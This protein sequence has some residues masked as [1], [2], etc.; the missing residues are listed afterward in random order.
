MEIGQS[1]KIERN[2]PFLYLFLANCPLLSLNSYTNSE[3]VHIVTPST[4]RRPNQNNSQILGMDQK[5][6]AYCDVSIPKL[7]FNHWPKL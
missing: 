2:L 4:T 5:T 3:L 1:G 6:S 7:F